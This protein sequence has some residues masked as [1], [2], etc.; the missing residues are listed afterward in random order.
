MSS[1]LKAPTL[2][3]DPT[4]ET[5]T[6]ESFVVSDAE[7]APSTP[8]RKVRTLH[9]PP[10]IWDLVPEAPKGFNRPA[11]LLVRLTSMN[12]LMLALVV[13][14]G[15]G[16]AV[17]GYVNWGNWSGLVHAASSFM[18]EP[19]NK[20]S[21]S[22]RATAPAKPQAS[23]EQ[24]RS[25]SSRAV[26]NT[27]STKVAVTAPEPQHPIAENA[28]GLVVPTAEPVAAP[29]LVSENSR[30]KPRRPNLTGTD[31]ALG[32]VP[33]RPSRSSSRSVAPSDEPRRGSFTAAKSVEEK[34][35]SQ[36]LSA[37]APPSTAPARATA[38]PKGKVIQWP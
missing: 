20:T 5:E 13:V 38:T 4:A 7:L 18:E 3:A 22:L 26:P 11:A 6:F 24:P 15:G 2:D 29:A 35:Q 9:E 32:S 10:E 25:D 21:S 37:P 27:K 1:I 30:V 14:L 17:F 8:V 33:K 12:P 19:A 16:G 31:P 23:S 28:A 36:P 34:T